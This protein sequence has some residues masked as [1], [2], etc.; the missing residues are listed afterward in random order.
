MLA[1]LEERGL[2]ESLGK[3]DGN[4]VARANETRLDRAVEL[5]L[6]EVYGGCSTPKAQIAL[7]GEYQVTSTD[8]EMVMAAVREDPRFP[9]E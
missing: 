6:A 2:V 9:N 8:D 3:A 4:L 1:Q 5:A 7:L